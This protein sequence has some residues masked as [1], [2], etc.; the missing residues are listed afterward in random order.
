[1]SL[2]CLECHTSFCELCVEKANLSIYIFIEL[3]GFCFRV[4]PKHTT[5]VTSSGNTE[6]NSQKFH[7]LELHRFLPFFAFVDEFL[8]LFHPSPDLFKLRCY[9]IKR[10]SFQEDPSP[11]DSK[12]RN[13]VHH[14]S[15]G[16]GSPPRTFFDA[17]VEFA[18]E[19]PRG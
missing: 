11:R 2:I 13:G 16:K 6:I 17:L 14:S 9:K 1:M 10:E 8:D 19:L 7:R 3:K 4:R 18:C 12:A 15:P 5:A